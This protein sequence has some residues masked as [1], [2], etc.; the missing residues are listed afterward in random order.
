MKVYETLSGSNSDKFQYIFPYYDFNKSIES[1]L[2]GSFNF[3]SSGSNTLQNTNNLKTVISNSLSYDSKDYFSD[4]GFRNNFGLYFKNFNATAKNDS[5]YKNSLQ[6]E[7]M[8]IFTLDSSF[9][10]IKIEKED[11]INSITPKYLLDTIQ[12][13]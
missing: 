10:L 6:S 2:N 9:P 1:D 13:T 8:T 4:L 5:T 3:S 12:L 11:I 7:L